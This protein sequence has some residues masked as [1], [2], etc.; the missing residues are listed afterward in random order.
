MLKTRK[1]GNSLVIPVPEKFGIKEG[2]EFIAFKGRCG[3]VIYVPKQEDNF[4]KAVRKGQSLKFEDEFGG[5]KKTNQ[6]EEK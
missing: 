3:S 4:E 2:K 1:Q 5:D 6:L